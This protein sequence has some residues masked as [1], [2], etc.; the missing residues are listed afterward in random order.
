MPQQQHQSSGPGA[1]HV[2]NVGGN[3]HNITQV[4][5]HFYPVQPQAPEV[6]RSRAEPFSSARPQADN[7]A[8]EGS[9]SPEQHKTAV[10]QILK[11]RDQL[12]DRELA[13]FK[14]F[15]D[16]EFQTQLVKAVPHA[17][18]HRVQL[19]LDTTIRNR[20]RTQ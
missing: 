7:A 10:S 5:Q 15:M 1:V 20:E 11:A 3:V 16:R 19:Y 14:R 18:L 13:G 17:K 12:K 4:H 6:A 2:G 8:Q 9:L